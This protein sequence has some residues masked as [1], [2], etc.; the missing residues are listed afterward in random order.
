MGLPALALLLLTTAGGLAA[1]VPAQPILNG[2]VLHDSTPVDSGTVTLHR[3]SPDVAGEV[4]SVRVGRNGSFTLRLPTVPDPSGREEI[5]FASVRYQG[6]LYFGPPIS[7]AAQLDSTYLIQVHDTAMVGPGGAPV[8]IAVRYLL[9]DPEPEDQGGGWTITDLIQIHNDTDRTFVGGDGPV[10][11]YPLPPE[12][13][14]VQVGGG[15]VEGRAVYAHADTLYVKTPVPPG[16]RQL[17]V[18]YYVGDL[19]FAIP[20][21]GRT[22]RLELLFREPAPPLDVTPLQATQP[23]QMDSATVY[24][25]YVGDNVV[26]AVIRVAKGR[27]GTGVPVKRVMIAVSLLL[28]GAAAWLFLQRRSRSPVPAP[29]D[30]ARAVPPGPAAAREALL[31]EIARLDQARER[32]ELPEAEWR[33][34]REALMGRLRVLQRE[35]GGG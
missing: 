15:D 28:A 8:G 12:V 34:R 25:H 9:A 14:E 16:D 4:D 6:V 22:D 18:R 17:V 11:Q 19:P 21:P 31:L 27:T 35:G 30:G 2:R 33:S 20:A 29:A 13:T 23:A 10:W 24:R 7:T 3:V 26:D 1:Q 5:Y 32:G